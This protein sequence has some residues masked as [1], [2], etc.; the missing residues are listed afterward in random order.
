MLATLA[1]NF[2]KVEEKPKFM[3]GRYVWR[4]YVEQIRS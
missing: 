2:L 4:V 1:Q 3:N